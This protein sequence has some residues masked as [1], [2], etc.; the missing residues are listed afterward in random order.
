MVRAVSEAVSSFGDGSVFIE[1]YVGSPRHIEI[2]I[3]ADSHGNIVSLF[4]RECS[5]QR[6]HQKVIEEA[7]AP[8]LTDT[9]RKQMGE[10]AIKAAVGDT[11]K[12]CK[13][14]HDEYKSKDYLY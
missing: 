12:A 1:R 14:C 3:L 6:R 5:I 9:T 7:P 11:G 2:Q 10:A 13:A 4:E 8:N